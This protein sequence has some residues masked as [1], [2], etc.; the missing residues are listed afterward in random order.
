MKVNQ[1]T[2]V[3]DAL[4]ATLRGYGITKSTATQIARVLQANPTA[5]SKD[6]SREEHEHLFQELLASVDFQTLGLNENAA[7]DLRQKLLNKYK[8]GLDG[9]LEG[10]FNYGPQT[11]STWDETVNMLQSSSQ[12]EWEQRRQTD[13]DDVETASPDPLKP[14]AQDTTDTQSS[15]SSTPEDLDTTDPTTQESDDSSISELVKE[16]I[17]NQDNGPSADSV[18]NPV[19]GN[20]G[21]AA[22]GEALGNI[23]SDFED[24]SGDLESEKSVSAQK[25][26]LTDSSNLQD[27]IETGDS[28]TTSDV[29]E[30]DGVEQAGDD[31]EDTE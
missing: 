18:P 10:P 14:S 1:P 15:M 9:D 17:I 25:D 26:E 7:A 5:R 6:L 12:E 19:D 3:Q 22:V 31:T 8:N 21:L 24:R 2:T 4:I 16:N 23:Q 30:S 11:D 29:D 27:D 13:T 20:R 28:T